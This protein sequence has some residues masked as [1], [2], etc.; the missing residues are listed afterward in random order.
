M[1]AKFHLHKK[2]HD[3][4]EL[5]ST[6]INVT[7]LGTDNANNYTSGTLQFNIGAVNT[8]LD[9]RKAYFRVRFYYTKADGSAIAAA[10]DLTGRTNKALYP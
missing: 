6:D 9:M 2:I 5:E 7:N 10:G 4:D 1:S 8:I 3:V